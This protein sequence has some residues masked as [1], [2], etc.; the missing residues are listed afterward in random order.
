MIADLYIKAEIDLFTKSIMNGNELTIG[1]CPRLI[2]V[3]YTRHIV[4]FQLL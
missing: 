4:F 1:N 2:P 3:L